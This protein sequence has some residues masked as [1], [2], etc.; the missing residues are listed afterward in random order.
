MVEGSAAIAVVAQVSTA[1]VEPADPSS[2]DAA[3]AWVLAVAVEPDEPE[4]DPAEV[5]RV[6]VQAALD[7]LAVKVGLVSAEPDELE[8]VQVE[9]VAVAPD[10]YQVA[11]V[12]RGEPRVEP[13]EFPVGLDARAGSVAGY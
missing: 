5:G 7:D 11:V 10:E 2:A 13:V 8:V 3:A 4:V 1:V 9:A 6:L 12:G